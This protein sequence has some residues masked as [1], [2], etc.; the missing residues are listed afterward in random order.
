MF[1]PSLNDFVWAIIWWLQGLSDSIMAEKYMSTSLK[2]C[3]YI[4][5]PGGLLS[6]FRRLQ[7]LHSFSQSGNVSGRIELHVSILEKI[8]R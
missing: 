1:I 6:N 4:S 2:I 5:L 7:L 8:A 3:T